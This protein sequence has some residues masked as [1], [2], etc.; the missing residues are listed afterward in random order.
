MLEEGKLKKILGVPFWNQ[1]MKTPT[2]AVYTAKL[3]L[4][5][6]AGRPNPSSPFTL[7]FS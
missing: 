5:W 1:A 6:P 4:G 7:N 3:K 2:G